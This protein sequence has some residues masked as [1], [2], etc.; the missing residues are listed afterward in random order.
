MNPAQKKRKADVRREL[1]ARKEVAL[2]RLPILTEENT[3]LEEEASQLKA[4]I[5]AH[6]PQCRRELN[7]QRQLDAERAKN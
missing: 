1:A 2:E 7:L 4:Q 3:T 6:E 5:A